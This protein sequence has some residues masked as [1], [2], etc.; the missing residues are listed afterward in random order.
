MYLQGDYRL[1]IPDIRGF[2]ASTH[3]GDVQSSGSM[4]D[5][6]GDVMCI[7]RYASVSKAVVIGQVFCSR[8]V[9]VA[10]VPGA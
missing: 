7:L 5:L 9:L 2:G 8:L 10:D 1:I 4:P 6:V 3:P